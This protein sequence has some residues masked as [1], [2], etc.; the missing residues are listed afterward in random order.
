[1]VVK[2]LNA[3]R[4]P[5]LRE[6]VLK[7]ELHQWECSACKR[8]L[9]VDSDFFWFD[10]HR[11]QFIGVFPTSMR[12]RPEPCEKVLAETFAFTM[13]EQAPDFVKDYGVGFFVRTVFG[14]EELREKIVIQDAGL[15]DF[16]VEM[17]KAELLLQ[18]PELVERGV[19]TLRLDG[20]QQNGSLL[21]VP[22]GQ[23]GSRLGDPPIVIGVNRDIYDALEP[24]REELLRERGAI[25]H[26]SHISLRSL[27]DA[28]PQEAVVP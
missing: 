15:D 14:V 1:M 19:V 18:H 25:I 17:V 23:D 6:Q 4:H 13:K 12:T 7:R 20:F 24:H 9:F 27:A 22:E 21:L 16:L 11:K 3:G 10:W 2:S 26:G 8:T 28:Q 5:H